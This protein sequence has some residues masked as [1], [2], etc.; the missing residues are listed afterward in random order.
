[1]SI[2]NKKYITEVNNISQEYKK[3]KGGV[4]NLLFTQHL[5]YVGGRY[6]YRQQHYLLLLI[7]HE[8]IHCYCIEII[9]LSENIIVRRLYL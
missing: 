1:M 8:Y 5:R 6:P 7:T 2:E 3:R 4:Y 9:I